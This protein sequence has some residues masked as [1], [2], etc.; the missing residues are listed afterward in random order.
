MMRMLTV[1]TGA[2]FLHHLEKGLSPEQAGFETRKI[3]PLYGNPDDTSCASGEDRSIPVELKDRVDI[4]IERRS[5]ENPLAYKNDMDTS[6]S[7]NALIRR[8]LQAGRL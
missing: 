8:E 2:C 3:H 4:Y 1:C 7:F 5:K 6:S